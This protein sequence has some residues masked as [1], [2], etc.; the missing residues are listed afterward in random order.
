MIKEKEY[1]FSILPELD[2]TI[3]ELQRHVAEAPPAKSPVL[4]YSTLAVMVLAVGIGSY[5]IFGDRTTPTKERI[6]SAKE[7]HPLMLPFIKKSGD[8][9]GKPVY[10]VLFSDKGTAYFKNLN[11]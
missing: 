6:V 2:I 4:R 11:F 5:F 9:M 8:A 7:E 10:G 3:D 1:K